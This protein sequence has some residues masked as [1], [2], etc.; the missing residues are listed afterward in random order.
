MK[1]SLHG[2]VSDRRPLRRGLR[3]D[4]RG[5]AYAEFLIAFPAMFTVFLVLVQ[6]GLI[7]AARLGV[8]HASVRAARAAV[9]VLPD[10]PRF[11]DGERINRLSHSE[12]GSN[13]A[14]ASFDVLGFAGG[15]PGGRGSTRL[16]AIRSAAMMPLIPFSPDWNS[17]ADEEA[18]AEAFPSVSTV[19]TG[20][21]IYTQAS[22]AVSF[23]T[24]PEAMTFQSEFGRREDVTTRVTYLFHCGIPVVSRWMCDTPFSIFGFDADPFLLR[25]T[26]GATPGFDFF[27]G[28]GDRIDGSLELMRFVE[29]SVLTMVA[30]ASGDRFLLLRSEAT[31][32]NQG[33][34]FAY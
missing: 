10:D 5:A 34:E 22:V 33:A 6:L 26:G 19:V 1:G 15:M 4:Q 29:N 30:I 32:T 31:M 8:A 16:R 23:P 13:S 21:L 14:A 27:S 18:L 24:E 3:R 20:G 7:Y 12:S 28:L 9:V 2:T 25:V 17:F 11:Y